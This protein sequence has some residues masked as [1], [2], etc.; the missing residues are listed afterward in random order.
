MTLQQPQEHCVFSW[1]GCLWITGLWQWRAAQAPSGVWI[2]ICACTQILGGCSISLSISCPSL[3][4][5]LIA[6]ARARLWSSFR[7]FSESPLLTHPKTMVSCL[8]G[9]SRLFPGLPPSQLW[10]TI[11]LTLCSRRQPQSSPWD[12]TSEARASAPSPRPPRRVS[13]QVSWAAECCSA[14]ILCAGISPLCPPHPCGCALLHG[15]EASPLC[16][17][18]SPPAKGLPSVWKPSLLHSSL[19]EVQVSSLFFCLFFFF[20]FALPRYVGIFLPFGKS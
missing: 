15:S 1:E 12:P 7:R 16:H 6:A 5:M 10:R 8:F 17:P 13:R 2:V 18:Q 20:S 9:W 11:P 3:V 4:S 19:P 14:R